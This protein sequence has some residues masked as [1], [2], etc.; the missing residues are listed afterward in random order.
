M[1]GKPSMSVRA[2]PDGSISTTSP[3]AVATKTP[4]PPG[5]A[6]MSMT[7]PCMFSLSSSQS[8]P[9]RDLNIALLARPARVHVR[10]RSWV[11]PR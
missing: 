6:H 5:A 7:P 9:S 11:I 8:A 10:G 4:F 2:R 1:Q 3:S